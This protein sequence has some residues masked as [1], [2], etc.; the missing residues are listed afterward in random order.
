[1]GNSGPCRA[2]FSD[3]SAELQN[4]TQEKCTPKLLISTPNHAA[5]VG[6]RREL[7]CVN[8]SCVDFKSY[9]FMGMLMGIA[10][11]SSVF[12]SLELPSLFWKIFIGD[13][14]LIDLNDLSE[15]DVNFVEGTIN[16]ILGLVRVH[17]KQKE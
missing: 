9:R 2:F 6:S 12:L 8:P 10:L 7:F 17:R 1:M 3:V 15:I 14:H 5:N 16:P 11:R 13:K 4:V